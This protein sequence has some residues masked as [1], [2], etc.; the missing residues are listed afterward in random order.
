MI[1]LI[2]IFRAELIKAGLFLGIF[3][4]S[5]IYV[6][7]STDNNFDKIFKYFITIIKL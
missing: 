1:E 2:K 6:T 7:V 5:I 4:L 3:S